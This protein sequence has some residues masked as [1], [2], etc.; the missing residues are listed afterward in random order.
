MCICYFYS[1]FAVVSLGKGFDFSVVKFLMA[2]YDDLKEKRVTQIE[3][4]NRND[5]FN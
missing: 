5:K 2:D 4:S 1:Q 3:C